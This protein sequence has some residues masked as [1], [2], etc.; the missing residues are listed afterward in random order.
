MSRDVSYDHPY[1]TTVHEERMTMVPGPTTQDRPFALF[2]SRVK[3]L[4]RAV[5]MILRSAPSEC[6]YH[7]YADPTA[8]SQ[9]SATASGTAVPTSCTFKVVRGDTTGSLAADSLVAGVSAGFIKTFRL[10]T[11]NT[12][13]TI[14]QVM[15]VRANLATMF[16]GLRGWGT[17]AKWASGKYDVIYEY[18]ILPE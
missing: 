4:V 8:V 12:L 3:V 17:G 15:G 1:F 13:H 7:T 2:R 5:T 9:V 6:V 18:E 14:T 11:K 10:T 16:I